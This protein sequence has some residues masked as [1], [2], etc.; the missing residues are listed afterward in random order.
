VTW[1]LSGIWEVVRAMNSRQSI[2]SISFL[3]SAGL[4]LLVA[5]MTVA[6]HSLKAALANPVDSLRYE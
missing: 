4:S 1:P 6:Y 3:L 2:R 5:L